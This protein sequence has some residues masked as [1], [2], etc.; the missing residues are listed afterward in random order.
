MKR[1]DVIRDVIKAAAILVSE[2]VGLSRKSKN[3]R[4]L[5]GRA[6]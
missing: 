4:N 1:L 5:F 6:H 2:G 3:K